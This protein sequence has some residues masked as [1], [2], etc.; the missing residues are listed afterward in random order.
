MC[1]P[2]KSTARASLNEAELKDIRAFN[3][4]VTQG[5]TREA[6][7]ALQFAFPELE[8]ISSIYLSQKTA[9]RL[10]GLRPEYVDCCVNSCCCYTGKYETLDRCPFPDCNEPRYDE[11]EQPR[12]RFQYLPIIPC[13]IALFLNKATMDKMNYRHMYGETRDSGKVTDVFDG[14]LYRELCEQQVTVNGK[15]LP[16]WYFSDHRD[17]ALGLS[18]D[19]FAPFKRRSNSAW[20]VILFNYNLPPTSGLTSTISSATGSFPAQVCQGCQFLPHSPL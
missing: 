20:P 7:E 11:N 12:K 1:L 3:Y 2:H 19:G 17:I 4:F 9:A 8:D 14:T 15:T 5:T 6:Y 13:L 18:L 10:S 16:H